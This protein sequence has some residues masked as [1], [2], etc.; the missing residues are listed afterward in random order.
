MHGR[1][2]DGYHGFPHRHEQGMERFH[3]REGH[4]GRGGRGGGSGE[5]RGGRGKRFFGRGDVKYVYLDLLSHE[6][7]HGYQIMKALEEKSDGLYS[8]SPGSIYPTLQMLED[9]G[10][11]VCKDEGGKKVY[12]ITDEGKA[13]LEEWKRRK[14]GDGTTEGLCRHRPHGQG[15]EWREM[16]FAGET[17][18]RRMHYSERDLAL[19]AEQ[20]DALRAFYEKARKELD[21]LLETGLFNTDNR[22]PEDEESD[23]NPPEPKDQD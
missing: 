9:R 23:R 7:M 22:E 21:Q 3:R 13:F 10:F 4:D 1:K 2:F 20:M 14:E 15:K 6:P 16:R 5:H 18:I 19:R 11:A 17:L 8:P 12:H